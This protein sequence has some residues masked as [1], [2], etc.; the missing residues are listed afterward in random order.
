LSALCLG[1]LL[2]SLSPGAIAE[3]TQA[4]KT[5]QATEHASQGAA[6]HLPPKA[7]TFHTATLGGEEVR[8]RAEAGALPLI[9]PQGKTKADIFYVA[10]A[11]QPA[12]TKRPV[13]FVFN[14]GPGAASAYLHIG[15]IGPKIVEANSHGELIGPPPRLV[16]NDSSWLAFTDLVFVDPVGTG[17]SHAVDGKDSDYWGV[18]QDTDSLAEF[19]RRYLID[20]GR[21]SSPVFLAGE[22]YGGFRAATI[23][24]K[25]Q[26]SGV[27]SPSGL[28]LISPALE[29][30]LI[31]GEDYDPLSWALS[32]PSFAAVKLES[33]GVSGREALGEALKGVEHYA[34]SD[35]LVALAS[36][37]AQGGKEASARVAEFT[38]LPLD[39]VEQHLARITPSFFIKQF[40]RAD[41]RLLSRYDGS[42]S[43][44]D[45]HPA[46]AWP[47]GPDPVLDSTVP[48][49]SSAFV[50]YAQN[51]LAYKTDESYQLLNRKVRNHWDFGTSPTRQGYA[52][53]L[54]D[55][56]EAR[57]S[58]P[59]LRVFIAAGYTDLITPYMTPTYL[60]NQLPPLN[61]AAPI[62][63]EDYAG[64]HMLY[65]RPDSRRALKD[66]VETMYRR[67]LSKVSEG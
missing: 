22:S 32:L 1:A 58:N 41:G 14:G 44:P 57:A 4:P 51:G 12:N 37:A 7:I 23:A 15:A 29:F 66:D 38:G 56:Q 67:A 13:T 25:L 9:S 5:E 36:G 21:M 2:F 31:D 6:L 3:D 20:A 24:R 59:A 50:N 8:Y 52:G 47:R 64:G 11:T 45:P 17:Y 63:V 54:D 35:Y 43:G 18:D 40:D 16:D 55:I 34:L 65:L 46:S 33:E 61:G 19:I 30:A 48:L 60:V 39:K 28:V 53:V 27:V 42:V 49:W 10:Y 26:K 62:T